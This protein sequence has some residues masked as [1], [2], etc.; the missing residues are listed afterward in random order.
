MRTLVKKF[1]NFCTGVFPRPKTAEMGTVEGDSLLIEPCL[2]VVDIPRMCLLYV[3]FGGGR[4][5]WA[6]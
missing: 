6:L 5:V 4:T 1:P 3:S 2:Q